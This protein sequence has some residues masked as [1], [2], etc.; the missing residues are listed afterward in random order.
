[1]AEFLLIPFGKL[2]NLVVFTKLHRKHRVAKV[3]PV[4]HEPSIA[5]PRDELS[6]HECWDSWR[7]L[8]FPLLERV[9]KLSLH[10][11]DAKITYLHEDEIGILSD[12]AHD[13]KKLKCNE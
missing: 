7:V 12:T 3:M 5:S 9:T 1:M 8:I 6:D 13:P 11:S 4:D 2:H 10:Q